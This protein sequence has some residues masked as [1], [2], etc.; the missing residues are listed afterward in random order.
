MAEM[1]EAALL[2]VALAGGIE[3]GQ[4]ARTAEAMRVAF[5]TLEEQLLE[6]DGDVLGKPDA[7]EAA[8][9][10]GV[11]ISDQAH[12]IARRYYLAGVGGA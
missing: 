6:G 3:Q 1:V 4:V 12:R 9:G 7:D 11:A 2:A 8:G 10:H 5:G